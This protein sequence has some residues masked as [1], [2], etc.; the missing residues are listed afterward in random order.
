MREGIRAPHTRRKPCGTGGILWIIKIE[1]DTSFSV[2][3]N[4][5]SRSCRLCLVCGGSDSA[6]EIGRQGRVWALKRYLVDQNHM[7]QARVPELHNNMFV[8]LRLGFHGTLVLKQLVKVR[9]RFPEFAARR[10]FLLYSV[11]CLPM[12]FG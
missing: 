3:L 12:E 4:L 2:M 5:P 7:I 6:V 10:N 1:T 9:L 11:T 8:C